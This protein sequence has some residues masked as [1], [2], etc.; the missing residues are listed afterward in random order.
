MGA[1]AGR[2]GVWAGREIRGAW[3]VCHPRRRG[4]HLRAAC[5]PESKR[6]KAMSPFLSFMP[7]P[8]GNA[9][10]GSETMSGHVDMLRPDD[11]A[12]NPKSYEAMRR[13]LW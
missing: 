10:T 13:C 11:S 3:E 9:Q 7:R 4:V 5:E 2:G 8:D 12:Q 6:A 1:A